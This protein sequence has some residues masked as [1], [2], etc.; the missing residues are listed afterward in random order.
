MSV[1][2]TSQILYLKL[3]YLCFNIDDAVAF[4]KKSKQC[5]YDKKS[6]LGL[7]TCVNW[8]VEQEKFL[9]EN[10]AAETSILTGKTLNA[11]K[12]KRTRLLK[13]E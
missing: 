2:K 10:G 11:C 5:I 4:I 6:K 7:L 3:N 13:K 9:I 12:V 8:T 1:W